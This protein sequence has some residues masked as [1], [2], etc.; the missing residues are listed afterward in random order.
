MTSGKVVRVHPVRLL[1]G[2]YRL[3]E[4]LGSGGMSV[5]W[6][7]HDEVLDRAVA[8]KVLAGPLASEPGARARIRAE[9]KAAAKLWHPHITN[10]YDYGEWVS[11]GGEPVPY[12][13][14]ELLP[15][16]TL[17]DRLAGGPLPPRSAMR[18]CAE[19][20]GALAAAHAQN[21]VHRDV[22]PSNVMLT[23]SGAKVLDFG[24]AALAGEP[25]L[26]PD[27]HRFGTP[28]YL[29]P[30]RLLGNE[31]V[32]ASDV[33][34][35]GLLIYRALTNRLPW[36]TETTVEMLTAHVYTEPDPLPTLS[37]VP[38]PVV[39]VCNRC[40]AKSPA[41]RPPAAAVARTLAAGAGLAAPEDGSAPL[42]WIPPAFVTGDVLPAA[43]AVGPAADTDDADAGSPEPG[44]EVAAHELADATTVGT[45]Q[46]RQEKDRRR[47]V[48]V[49]GLV[50]VV[51]TT[52]TVA[53]FVLPDRR[54]PDGGGRAAPTAGGTVDPGSAGPAGSAGP[55]GSTGPDGG[56]EAGTA[57]PDRPAATSG[58]SGPAAGP[59]ATT[60]APGPGGGTPTPTPTPSPSGGGTSLVSIG[61]VVV[62]LCLGRT[63][64]VVGVTPSLGYRVQDADRGPASEVKVVFEKGDRASEVRATCGNGL[65]IPRIKES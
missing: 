32:P 35:L 50:A 27:G 5:V 4:H 55:G 53:M 43:V 30:E 61:G 37:G 12:V 26:D 40:L 65:P 46:P 60:A 59:A 63:A 64:T 1:D 42:A 62:V 21:L 41:D 25:E 28:A 38:A 14:M 34:A 54:N 49:V 17:A 52:A 47:T 7:A 57:A 39:E 31:V 29:A 48:A 18:I 33:Y 44:S 15:G 3:D 2:R 51:V 11:P 13:V 24:I 8:V 23:P 45:R 56:D 58:P 19:V 20:A 36:R 6:R 9:A 22:K 10:V 16:Q